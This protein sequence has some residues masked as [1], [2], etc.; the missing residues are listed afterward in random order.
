MQTLPTHCLRYFALIAIVAAALASSAPASA[1]SAQSLWIADTNNGRVVELTPADLKR[2]GA[3][4]PVVLDS[5]ILLVPYG[6][7]FDQSN[8]LW[9]WT[10][11]NAKVV[12]FTPSQLSKLRTVSNPTPNATIG[13]ADFQALD[14]CLFDAA[15]DLWIVDYGA[16]G[17]FELTHSQLTAGS[18]PSITPAIAITSPGNFVEAVYG[19]FDQSGNLWVSNES[20]NELLEFSLSQ[21]GSSGDKAPA[22]VLSSSD[23]SLD[24]PG[25]AAFDSKGNLWVANFDNTTVV[26]FAKSQLAASG[27]PTPVLTLSSKALG[28]P[29][30]LAFDS[31]KNL[32]I[33]DYIASHILKFSSKRLKKSGAPT[34]SVTLTGAVSGSYQM[35]FGPVF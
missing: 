25:Q 29:W 31:S 8:D 12:E 35:T 14:G 4:T 21:L 13:S 26:M 32:W 30:G 20:N 24:Y 6:L 3:P 22:V 5:S 2:S 33:S 17:L 16:D 9:V 19:V 28:N 34:P 23:G 27:S 11:D 1:K 18:S 15:G 10:N 7:V